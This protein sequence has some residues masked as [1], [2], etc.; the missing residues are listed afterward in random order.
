[1]IGGEID[2][3]FEVGQEGNINAQNDNDNLFQEGEI[4]N[5]DIIKQRQQL[6]LQ[7]KSIFDEEELTRLQKEL[8][9]QQ[10]GAG[11]VS[12]SSLM[13]DDDSVLFNVNLNRSGGGGDVSESMK[14]FGDQLSFEYRQIYDKLQD[15]WTVDSK[16][17][18]Q[19]DVSIDLLFLSLYSFLYMRVLQ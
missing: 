8:K 15:K 6:S 5:D 12:T 17:Q 10:R 14:F 4:P 9:N 11:R 19:A 13:Q 16:F 3:Q 18:G 7:F 2:P 1:M